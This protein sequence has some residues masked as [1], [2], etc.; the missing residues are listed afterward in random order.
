MWEYTFFGVG[1]GVPLPNVSTCF[2]LLSLAR[3]APPRVSKRSLPQCVYR[4][5]VFL[6]PHNCCTSL[7][8]VFWT[9]SACSIQELP[10]LLPS[11]RVFFLIFQATRAIF[12]TLNAW[13]NNS[14]ASCRL[15]WWLYHLQCC[16]LDTQCVQSKNFHSSCRLLVS[17]FRLSA[18]TPNS[19]PV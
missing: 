11:S 10:L 8:G 5:S 9:L 15:L 2:V 1:L 3:G 7:F 6:R 17:F 14:H 18:P 19:S 16:F 4:P 12:G 13:K